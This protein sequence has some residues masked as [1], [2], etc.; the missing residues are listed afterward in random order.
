MRRFYAIPGAY[1][2][3]EKYHRGMAT[4]GSRT[5][6]TSFRFDQKDLEQLDKIKELAGLETRA[7]VIRH[8]ANEWLELHAKGK[9]STGLRAVME[10][11]AWETAKQV[12][13]MN[14]ERAIAKKK[15]R[16]STK[17]K[18]PFGERKKANDD[19]KPILGS[20]V[21]AGAKPTK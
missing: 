1:T 17:K 8:V 3:R 14:R 5:P 11:L 19:S 12:L 21:I 13:S 2:K 7:D 16:S 10:T 4:E 15:R 18:A 20:I 6:A 9:L